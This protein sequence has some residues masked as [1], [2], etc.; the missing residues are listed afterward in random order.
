MGAHELN[1]IPSARLVAIRVRRRLRFWLQIGLPLLLVF[2]ALRIDLDR[3]LH[4][5]ERVLRSTVERDRDRQHN[6]AELAERE[7]E[8][9]A[10]GRALLERRTLVPPG[11]PLEL[12]PVLES[13]MGPALYLRNLRVE[14]VATAAVRGAGGA[15]G[16][17]GE[18]SPSPAFDVHLEGA[19]PS[20]DL[21]AS[22]LLALAV[23]PDMSYTVLDFSRS[24]KGD[25]RR[26][27]VFAVNTRYQPGPLA[28]RA[29]RT[30][31][32]GS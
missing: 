11:S 6:L 13:A 5:E 25:E 4:R 32:E 28:G 9:D 31:G 24:E 21:V 3:R 14:P 2:P 7:E 29:A 18:A 23:R 12:F 19:A 22:F 17:G 26:S 15:S 1:L 27:V 10:L 30:P 8:R 16:A 20:N